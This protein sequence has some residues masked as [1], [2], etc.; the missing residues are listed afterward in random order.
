MTEPL[1]SIVIPCYDQARFVRQAVESCLAQDYD[2][3]EII[4]VDDGSSDNVQGALG[5]LLQSPHL[6]FLQQKNRG[7]SEARNTGIAAASG[8]FLKFLDADDWLAPTIVSKQ[9]AM[10]RA[11]PSLGFVYC[12]RVRVDEADQP[13][14]AQPIADYDAN[15]SG[16][17]F[18]LLLR[19]GFFPPFTVLLP[20]AVLERVGTFDS[21]FAGTEDYDLWLRIT[22]MGYAV[23]FL[24]EPLGYYRRQ[25]ASVSRDSA[26]MQAQTRAVLSKI[27]AA[28][29]E[30]TANALVEIGAQ[31]LTIQGERASAASRE[32]QQR[33]WVAQLELEKSTLQRAVDTREEYLCALEST[34]LMQALL[35]SRLFPRRGEAPT[36][37]S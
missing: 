15:L 31:F 21:Q 28:F 16:D 24:S 14:E 17:L 9:V 7:V 20:R 33:E 30:R 18:A 4:V 2:A 13:L 5:E 3:L 34:P 8:E 10:L 32:A 25:T 1:V 23:Q 29:P 22:G 12:D 6:K 35:S 27:V 26:Y 37:E 11:D 19:G 36:S